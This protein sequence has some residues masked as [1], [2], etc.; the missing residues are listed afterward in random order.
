MTLDIP[1]EDLIVDSNEDLFVVSV[2]KVSAHKATRAKPPQVVLSVD[3][4]LRG[5]EQKI[6]SVPWEYPYDPEATSPHN[7]APRKRDRE[8]WRAIAKEPLANP[9]VGEQW[10]I[11]GSFSAVEG[12]PEEFVL[13]AKFP[14]SEERRRWVTEQFAL[15]KRYDAERNQ[16][17][18]WW[19]KPLTV[20]GDQLPAGAR[21]VTAQTL[22]KPGEPVLLKY[23]TT[24]QACVVE[25]LPGGQ[26]KVRRHGDDSRRDVV[27]PREKLMLYAEGTE[28]RSPAASR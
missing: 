19:P 24:T 21:P 10:L 3:E 18:E 7:P 17:R 13:L 12:E 27:V 6:I 16:F 5:E 9:K 25:A 28:A 23:A 20:L 11:V 8:E 2:S 1:P 22:L 26:V 15:R 4:T 14:W